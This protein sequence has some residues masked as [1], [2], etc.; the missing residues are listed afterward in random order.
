MGVDLGDRSGATWPP[1]LVELKYGCA[2]AV[3]GTS[4]MNFPRCSADVIL[5][6]S[7]G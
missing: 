5:R 6:L 1:P 2:T 3:K 7:I 4:I